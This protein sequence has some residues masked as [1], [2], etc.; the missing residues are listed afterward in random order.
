[1]TLVADILETALP[2]STSVALAASGE[3]LNERAGT[4]NLGQEGTLSL[5]AVAA[6]IV[7]TNTSNPFLALAVGVLVGALAGIAFATAAVVLHGGRFFGF[8]RQSFGGVF[9]GLAAPVVALATHDK[10]IIDWAKQF[11]NEHKVA[12]TRFEFQMLYGIRSDLQ[13]QLCAEG[14]PVRVYVPYG[15]HWYPYFMRRLAERPANVWF[16]VRTLFG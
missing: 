8:G 7:G 13:R 4:L 16:V 6:F 2:A 3:M 12:H 14:Y 10:K 5:G 9:G 15:G 1:V 11:I